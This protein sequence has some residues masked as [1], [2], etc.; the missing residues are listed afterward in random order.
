[1]ITST[2]RGRAGW[3]GPSL[4]V[5]LALLVAI[6]GWG[7]GVPAPAEA[8]S[9]GNADQNLRSILETVTPAR[10]GIE[11]TVA[12]DGSDITITNSTG[13]QV[14]VLGYQHEPF[15]R[16][17][18]DG[19]WRNEHS[20]TAYAVSDTPLDTVPATGR[21]AAPSWHRIATSGTYFWH[22]DRIHATGE[23]PRGVH[24]DPEKRQLVNHWRIPLQ[25]AGTPGAITGA[26]WWEPPD[27][28]ATMVMWACVAG[29]A[30]LLVL[31]GWMAFGRRST[32]P[33]RG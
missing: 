19:V 8:H 12:P 5:R 21:R 31:A 9:G 20:L 24:D 28:D 2:P 32:T 3:S 11:V 27:W 30:L 18:A 14:V 1:M 29:I 7:I 16:I 6:G 15:L 22:D 10:A 4:L 23:L 17:T 25:V 26:V 33:D 13:Q